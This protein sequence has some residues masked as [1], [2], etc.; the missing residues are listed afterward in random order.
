VQVLGPKVVS[1][2]QGETRNLSSG[3]VFVT[4]GAV[5]LA[6]GDSIEYVITLLRTTG[7]PDVV[8]LRCMGKILRKDEAS[9]AA[10]LERYEFV[11]QSE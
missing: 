2:L 10:T 8:R 6:P 5:P 1:G 11:R 3:G 4:A 7:Q 9:F